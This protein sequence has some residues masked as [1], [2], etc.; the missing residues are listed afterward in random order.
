MRRDRP[1]AL[2]SL[3]PN[4]QPHLK[5][6]FKAAALTA[7]RRPGPFKDY[8]DQHLAAGHDPSLVRLTVTRKLAAL[9]LKLWKQGGRYQANY[10]NCPA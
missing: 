9:V 1:P 6:I 3:N 7:I 10:G 5:E 2:R 4:H 8:Y